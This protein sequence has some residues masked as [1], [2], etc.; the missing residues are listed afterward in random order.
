MLL[1]QHLGGRQHRCLPTR[2]D[3]L[4][5]RTQCH[6][7]LA[8]ADV[9]LEQPLHR[10][11][12]LEVQGDLLAHA[13]LSTG[14]LI[15]QACVEGPKKSVI[16]CRARRSRL[17]LPLVASLGQHDLQI[18]GLLE[19]KSSRGG[20]NVATVSGPMDPAQ[21]FAKPQKAAIGTYRRGQRI[22]NIRH[23]VQR[24]S[25]CLLDLPTGQPGRGRIDGDEQIPKGRLGLPIAVVLQRRRFPG[26]AQ[27]TLGNHHVPWMSELPG[28]SVRR[29]RAGEQSSSTDPE[30]AIDTPGLI[31]EHQA[32]ASGSIGHD[33]FGHGA[34][35][36]LHASSSR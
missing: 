31:E 20:L 10:M 9:T 14:Q 23:R 19:A 13:T 17:T 26:L 24:E 36:L 3:H 18:E 32:D 33:D 15:G 30:L 29:D 12:P 35:A 11:G 21:R 5:H 28:A 22:V 1:R 34:L 8:A 27:A 16:R 6:E 25:H 2:I 7:G 4:Q